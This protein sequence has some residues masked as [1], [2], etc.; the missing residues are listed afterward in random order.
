MLEEN[1]GKIHGIMHKVIHKLWITLWI[2]RDFCWM[3]EMHGEQCT[4]QTNL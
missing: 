3:L 1:N 2:I 4:I